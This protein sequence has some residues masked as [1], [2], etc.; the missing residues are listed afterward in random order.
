MV[1]DEGVDS[2]LAVIEGGGAPGSAAVGWAE[3]VEWTAE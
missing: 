2:V 1:V 3:E